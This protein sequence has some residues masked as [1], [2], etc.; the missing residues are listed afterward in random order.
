MAKDRFGKV[1]YGEGISKPMSKWFMPISHHRAIRISHNARVPEFVDDKVVRE[2]NAAQILTMSR[3]VYG[4][5]HSQWI[6]ETVQT[7][8][9]I[10]K[11][12]RDV[13]KGTLPDANESFFDL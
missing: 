2:L 8:G 10:Y 13:F 9:G 4:R 6:D 11:F 5:H 7:Y 1:S 12:N 3:R